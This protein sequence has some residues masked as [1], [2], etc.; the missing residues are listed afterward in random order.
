M[1]AA[2]LSSR[3]IQDGISR[4]GPFFRYCSWSRLREYDGLILFLASI[5]QLDACMHSKTDQ[6]PGSGIC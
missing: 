3:T 2:N 6:L 1:P 4:E 5:D